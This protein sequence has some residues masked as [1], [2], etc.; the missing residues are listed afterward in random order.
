MQY[1]EA[2]RVLDQHGQGHVLRFWN[3]LDTP[4]QAGLLSQIEGL[5]FATISCIPTLLQAGGATGSA[6]GPMVPAPVVTAAAGEAAVPQSLGEAALRAN[7]VGVILVAG[8]QGTRLGYDGPK[9]TY[10]L[11]SL[12]GASLFE[13]HARK[14]LALERQYQAQIPFY[15]MTSEG[16]DADTRAFFEANR[17]FGLTSDRVKFFVQGTLPAFLP[18]G[19]MVL[20][21]PGKLFAAPDGHGGILSALDRRGMLA[22]MKKRGLTTLF[23]FQVDNALVDIADPVF[24]GFHLQRKADMSLKVCSKRDPDEGLGVTVIRDGRYSVVEYIELTKEQK[25]ARLPNGDL[26]LKF[27]SVAIHIFSLDFLVRETSAGLPLHP[28]FKKVPYCDD[29]G[30]AVKPE[31]PNAY[32]IEKFIFDAL[33][34][35]RESLILEFSREDEFA[36][37][38]NAEGNDS[39]ETARAAMTEKFARWLAACGVVVPRD[40]QGRVAVK[41]EIDPVFAHDAASL[42]ARLPGGFRITGDV[43]LKA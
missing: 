35:A 11:A 2:K 42:R 20:E 8:G 3:Q 4:Q 34:D 32:K 10:R 36:P 29:Q 38:K 37:V 7:Q 39:P 27:G 31:K 30:V 33:P 16:N 15:I 24:V 13:I 5:D 17:F 19:R 26:V 18:D 43:L 28:S 22:D 40:A 14:I 41:I 25:N 9:G 12:T 6:S 23:F 21:S 1:Q